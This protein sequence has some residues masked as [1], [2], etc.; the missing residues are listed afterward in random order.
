MLMSRLIL[1]GY[2]LNSRSLLIESY[3]LLNSAVLEVISYCSFSIGRRLDGLIA[4]QFERIYRKK[5]AKPIHAPF[6]D[7][8][9]ILSL[10]NYS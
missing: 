3:T 1:R 8:Y 5:D 7:S 10:I 2:L 6:A 9:C 4:R